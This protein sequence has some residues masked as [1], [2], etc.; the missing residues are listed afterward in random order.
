VIKQINQVY[1]YVQK[2]DIKSIFIVIGPNR[3][4]LPN[5]I[6]RIIQYSRNKTLEEADLKMSAGP[7]TMVLVVSPSDRPSATELL[8]AT[9][10]M[11]SLRASF[12]DVYFAYVARNMT[13]FQN[14]NYEYMD[15]SE[16]FL[17][18]SN[19]L[20][21]WISQNTY[22]IAMVV[23]IFKQINILEIHT[24]DDLVQSTHL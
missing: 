20:S 10:L 13:D 23:Y 5:I 12:F 2:E 19:K 16:L 15:Y 17:T 3:L 4:N 6:S 14:I 21:C 8:R 11:Y 22:N 18:V 7:S 9:E 1:K 24:H